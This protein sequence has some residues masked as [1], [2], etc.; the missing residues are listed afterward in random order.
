MSNYNYGPAVY[1]SEFLR[2]L[3]RSA[4]ALQRPFSGAQSRATMRIMADFDD[5]VARSLPK[6]DVFIGLSGVIVEAFRRARNDFGAITI[7]ERG[8]AHVKVQDRLIART[9]G[10]GALDPEYVQRELDG[11]ANSDYVSVPSTFAFNSFID[12]GYP[13]NRLFKNMYGVNLSRFRLPPRPAVMRRPFRVLFVGG[14]SYQKGCDMLAEALSL[15]GDWTL[16]HAGL[17]ADL[18]FPDSD[19]FATLGHVPNDQLAEVYADHDA[20]ILPSRQD[21]FGMVLLEALACGLHIL[22]SPFTGA[23]DIREHLKT[24]ERVRTI[25]DLSGVGIQQEIKKLMDEQE[26]SEIA[27]TDPSELDAFTWQAY[28]VRYANFLAQVR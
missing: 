21:G 25:A 10:T 11:Y 26:D 15:G 1:R 4:V 20:F 24:T 5:R 23:S 9:G 18:P 13:V 8:S 7:C 17:R 22:A 19:R 27:A 14:W 6:C 2:M 3:P 12:E 28:G 16:T